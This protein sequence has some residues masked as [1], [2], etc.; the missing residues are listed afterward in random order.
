[1]NN[2]D[3]REYSSF[4]DPSGM[5]FYRDG[6]LYRQIN[7]AYMSAYRKLMDSGLYDAL[8]KERLLIV[9]KETALSGIDGDKNALV[10]QPKRIPFIS[11]P[12]EWS[13]EQYKQA[14]I[15]TLRAHLLA[16][17]YGMALKDASAYNIQFLNGYAVLIDTL[18]FETYKE[19]EPWI[20]Y[21]QF[22]RHFLAPLLMMTY[23]DVRLSAMMRNF[24][25]GIP[26]DLASTLLKRK[27][28]F[29]TAQHIRMHAKANQRHGED[30][31][32]LAQGKPDVQI[33]KESFIA[34]AQSM[35]YKIEKM[36]M[37]GVITEWGDYY[38][39][40]NYTGKA[41]KDKERIVD[42]YI[43]K[44]AKKYPIAHTW[45]LG[46]NDGRYSRL[47]LKHS[48][49]VVA[50]DIDA[51]AVERNYNA[52]SR[53]HEAML[54]MLLD[55]TNP[56]TGIG[57]AGKERK[58][59]WERQQPDV[60]MMLALI[61]HIAISNNIPLTMIAQWVA[62]LCKYLI[63]EFVPKEDSQ[64]KLLLA[65][66]DDIFTGYHIAGFESAFCEHF[67][68]IEKQKLHQSERILYLF[69][70]ISH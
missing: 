21:G 7:P 37:K 36:S 44:I 35:L 49:H 61:H 18:S 47:A 40:T 11:Y 23:L 20:A 38:S 55:L 24:I 65:T 13:F 15:V 32:K 1:M 54:P 17:E 41:E 64:V 8:V 4:R 14:A 12:Y 42:S 60:V 25:D 27:G 19:G 46:A 5:I 50:F 28:G 22:C 53:S 52:V 30:G 39:A 9:H 66:R 29:F 69:R 63:I 34:L 56:S 10:I 2:A 16:M 6:I 26:L 48:S 58:A 68:L 45:D 70:S 31:K 3:K 59:I 57:F 62:S 67:E 33:S 43:E 51:V